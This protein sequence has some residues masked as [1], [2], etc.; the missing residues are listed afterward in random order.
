MNNLIRCPKPTLGIFT[1][2]QL[3]LWAII[4]ASYLFFGSAT[5]VAAAEYKI[6]EIV[7]T[8]QKR[9]AEVLQD[10]P[11]TITAFSETFL[12]TQNVTDFNDFGYQVPGLIFE[13][14]GPGEKR[15]SLRGVRSAGQ[16]QVA[17][18][19]DEVPI[20]G[21]QSSTSDSGG[22]TSDLK[23]FDVERI[24]VLKGPQ[25]TLFGAN[26]QTGTVRFISKKP[27][28]GGFE[29]EV[30]GKFSKTSNAGDLNYDLNAM[31]NIPLIKDELALRTVVY[32]GEDG[33][34]IDN[35]R[36]GLEDINDVKTTGIRSSLRWQPSDTFT[37]DAMAWLQNRD[38]GGSNSYHPFDTFGTDPN[39]NDQGRNDS[40]EPSTF[41]QTG[42]FS[43][44]DFT[45][46]EKPDD[47]EIFS[48]TG[49]WDMSW[50]TLTATSSY[51]KRDFDFKFDSTWIVLF[52]GAEGV[53]DD[54]FPAVTDQ[55]QSVEQNM[56]EIRLNSN[57]EGPLNWLAGAFYRE[58][59]S[60]FQS[61]V[62]V[63]DSQTGR[64]FDPGTPFTGPSNEVGA[65]I[66]G[67]HPCVFARVADKTIEEKALF[68]EI[69]YALTDR[70]EA[71]FGL[72]WFDV[73]QSDFG[74]TVFQFALFGSEVPAPNTGRSQQDEFIQKYKLSY[75]IDDDLVYAVAS[76]GYRLGGTNNQGIVA[77][78]E[79][80]EADEVWNYEIGYKS[81]WL[82]G[83]LTFNAALY[84]VDFE[85]IQVAGNDP[86]GAFGFIG[87]AGVAE[88]NG[89][90]MEL[91]GRPNYEW[92]YSLGFNYLSKKELTED[93]V[94]D[95]I[96]APGAAGQE[97]PYVPDLTGFATL[98]R[99]F[100]AGNEWTG[101]MRAEYN[102]RGESDTEFD[103]SSSNSRNQGSYDILNLRLGISHPVKQLDITLFLEN[104]ADEDGDLAIIRAA[105]EPTRKITNRPRTVGI[106]FVKSF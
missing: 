76:Q 101:F 97:L 89:V 71:T 21:V 57:N 88:V 80:F 59:D 28:S 52:L 54:L 85:N 2:S 40:V 105:G 100:E 83:A 73:E 79:L 16:Q 13:D 58:R 72:R 51:Y 81:R 103:Q 39:S 41:F 78:P 15:Y 56:H 77:V 20:P 48:L 69:N 55:A 33:G 65:G 10:I 22:Q 32:S 92:E 75:N 46:T 3:Q 66:P 26:S 60:K 84:K 99:N 27:N 5:V 8:A 37:L 6:E 17:V 14:Q 42:E 7:V 104:A 63:V 82:D 70:L 90:E 49:V 98:Q 12:E 18:Y 11:A 93:Q 62:P 96:Q 4:I 64:A 25:G 43:T 23:L 47:Q 19:Y 86:T 9:G 44:G 94:S 68:G 30:G 102:Y 95:A 91:Y 24:E 34:Y 74:A 31:L 53:R 36:L 106:N 29:S 45:R 50:A 1:G 87:N 38:V 67:C 61:F 35:V